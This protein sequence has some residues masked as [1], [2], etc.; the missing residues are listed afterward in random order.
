MMNELAP[1]YDLILIDCPPNLYLGDMGRP[2]PH[3]MP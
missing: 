1:R 2:W 3:P